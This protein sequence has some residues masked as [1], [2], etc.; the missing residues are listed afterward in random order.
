MSKMLLLT[1]KPL[2]F[3]RK[4]DAKENWGVVEFVTPPKKVYEL[5]EIIPMMGAHRIKFTMKPVFEW[6]VENYTP[7]DYILIQG[8]VG[9]CYLMVN[10]IF[11]FGF[12]VTPMYLKV[13]SNTPSTRFRRYNN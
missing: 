5:W 12:E 6:F 10:F 3:E 9:A 8:D 2:T 13:N 11:E 1:E 4:E 7:G